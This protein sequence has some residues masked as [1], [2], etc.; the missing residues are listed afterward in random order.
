VQ[1]AT[2]L[3]E[4]LPKLTS[5][6]QELVERADALGHGLL[7][8]Q[9]AAVD[10]GTLSVRGNLE[11]LAT[12][13]LVGIT[14]P[15]AYGGLG[16]GDDVPLRVLEGLA[17]GDGTTPFV[18]AQHYGA[19]SIIAASPNEALRQSMLP[20]MT[21]GETLCGFGI[22]QVRR[23][24][25][26]ALA[27]TA[28]RDGEGYRFDGV[29]PW[30]TGYDLF[31]RVIIAGTL[32]D[33]R[34]LL[35]LFPFQESERLRIDGVMDLVAMNGARTVS[36]TVDGLVARPSEVVHIEPA[37]RRAAANR[38]TVPCLYGLA[39]ASGDDLAALAE[40]RDAPSFAD[41]AAQLRNRLARQRAHFY[42]G[43]IDSEA[44]L[45]EV[46]AAATALAFDAVAALTIATAGSANARTSPVQ[47]RLREA[48][49]FATWGL[50]TT[51]STVAVAALASDR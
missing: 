14:V 43:G 27:A 39:R 17:Y 48:S 28:L 38:T 22:S 32:P 16:A 51:A 26:P 29:I 4:A 21:T 46:R 37:S 45:A 34:S 15:R 49:V 42:G 19:A 7:A 40:R 44:L 6:E 12:D 33:G 18:I 3:D 1:P 31:D 24:G 50:S 25:K 35:A 8:E 30:M 13:G 41:A 36:A 5:R 9:A 2:I 11:R 23:A 10:A 47:R 20:G